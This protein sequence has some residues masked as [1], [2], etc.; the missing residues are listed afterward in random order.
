MR[1]WLAETLRHWARKLD[2]QKAVLLP[3]NAQVTVGVAPG[4]ITIVARGKGLIATVPSPA[5]IDTIGGGGGGSTTGFGMAAAGGYGGGN[6]GA[7]SYGPGST[8]AGG[9]TRTAC[10]CGT[11]G[12]SHSNDR[13]G[14]QHLP[15]CPQYKRAEG[16]P[17]L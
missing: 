11:F 7:S 4:I 13:P 6:G 3:P 16:G 2:G 8:S 17:V 10:N 12:R 9:G 1:L 15:M 14:P 5:R